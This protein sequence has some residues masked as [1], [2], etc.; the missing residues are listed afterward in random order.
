[1][2]ARPCPPRSRPPP[3]SPRASTTASSPSASGSRSSRASGVV[4]GS[5]L[6]AF[7]DTPRRPGQDPLP[8]PAAHARV[9]GRR[10]RR[11]PVLRPRRR[12]ARR[13]HAG[14]RAPVRGSPVDK[15][16]QGVRTMA[17]LGVQCVLLTNAAGGLEP[18]W[19]AGDLMVVTDHL[20]L[21]GTSPLIGPN[22]DAIGPRFPDMTRGLRPGLRA[23]PSR[24]WRSAAGIALREGV[25]AGLL[26]PSVRD[27]RRGAH[28]PRARGAGRRNE[29]RPRGHR[30]AA[31]GREG[32]RPVVHHEPRRGHRAGVRSITPRWRRPPGPGRRSSRRCCAGG[33]PAP[34]SC[35]S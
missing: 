20:N 34:G 15:V 17:R 16:V 27:A 24:A 32:R 11:Q 29:H 35:P 8:R 1:M 26:G 2:L 13:V 9:G 21:T 22:D 3:R 23:G 33:L 19:A 18:S 30:P 14:S 10:P 7:A 12:R 28:G 31:H 6:G 25:Y 4:L 5:G